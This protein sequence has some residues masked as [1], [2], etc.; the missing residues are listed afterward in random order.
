MVIPN[1]FL[2]NKKRATPH[3][4][5]CHNLILKWMNS[6]ALSSQSTVLP[7]SK[8]GKKALLTYVHWVCAFPFCEICQPS[9][10]DQSFLYTNSEHHF[11]LRSPTILKN[12]SLQDGCSLIHTPSLPNLDFRV[13]I[14]WPQ[15][16]HN[17]SSIGLLPILP[18]SNLYPPPPFFIHSS[19]QKNFC[20]ACDQNDSSIEHTNRH[21]V[22]P[23]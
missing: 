7:H 20:L 9:L 17:S 15:Q 18:I 13:Y 5:P 21:P 4:Y 11:F 8:G 22:F 19:L 1:P 2:S 10:W 12:C 3:L 23:V 14:G 16:K 6:L